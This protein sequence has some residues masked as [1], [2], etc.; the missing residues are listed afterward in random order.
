MISFEEFKKLDL[1]VGEIKEAESIEKSRELMKFK[2][3]VGDEVKQMV[4]GFKKHYNPKELIGKKVIV[5]ANLEPAK[6]FG[7]KSEG[8]ILA[9][10]S[11]NEEVIRMIVPDGEA[12]TGW[13]VY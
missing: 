9:A 4:G 12:E 5:I 13:K 10:C 2:I 8:M 3:D 11:P 7:I 1:R 6:L